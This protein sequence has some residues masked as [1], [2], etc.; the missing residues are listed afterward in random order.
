MTK[1]ELKSTDE[2][3]LSGVKLALDHIQ[4]VAPHQ[5]AV[6]TEY[7]LLLREDLEKMSEI[8]TEISKEH[9]K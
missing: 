7:F 9:F 3:E 5:Y 4:K 6:I 1:L 8:L 2:K